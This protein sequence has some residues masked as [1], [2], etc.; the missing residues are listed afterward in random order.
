MLTQMRWLL[1]FCLVPAATPLLCNG[2]HTSVMDRSQENLLFS[3][4]A[5]IKHAA[6]K[7]RIDESHEE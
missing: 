3:D 4:L 2:N 1:T 6:Q 7:P 5:L